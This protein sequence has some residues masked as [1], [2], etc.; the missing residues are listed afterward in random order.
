MLEFSQGLLFAATA[1]VTVAWGL[2]VLVVFAARNVKR[3]ELVGAVQSAGTDK[4]S[5]EVETTPEPR[6][7][8]LTVAS[9]LSWMAFFAL[10]ASA[11]LR[12]VGTG[13]PPMANHYEFAVLFCWGMILFHCYFQWRYRIRTLAV[14]VLPVIIAML[15]YATTLSYQAK[16]LMPALQNSPLLTLHVF[17]AALSYGAAV[18]SFGAAV[19]F[20]IGQ[21][22]NRPGWPR[23]EILDEVGYKAVIFTF[24]LLT[25]MIVLGSVW[26]NIAWG[27]YWSWD[28]KETAALV[29]WFIYGGYL[30]ARVVR[31][32]SGKRAAWLLV[33]GFVAIIFTYFGNLWFGGMHSYA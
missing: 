24:P 17:T 30:H 29:T 32:W 9:G 28:P 14:F 3:R 21:R 1:L 15:A 25:I 23:A 13:H 26:A 10:S 5:L 18:V 2:Y 7:G 19:M 31:G 16:P 27:R 8:I 12:W 20:L 4:P 33:I 11:V 22:T 6:G